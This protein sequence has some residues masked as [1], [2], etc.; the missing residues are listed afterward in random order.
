VVAAMRRK[1]HTPSSGGSD[2]HTTYRYSCATAWVGEGGGG[3]RMGGG[4]TAALVLTATLLLGMP[5]CHSGAL[6]TAHGPVGKPAGIPPL[7][8]LPHP[9]AFFR[10]RAAPLTYLFFSALDTLGNDVGAPGVAVGTSACVYGYTGTLRASS[11]NKRPGCQAREDD[12][13]SVYGYGTF[14]QTVG[15]SYHGTS[16]RPRRMRR[17][18]KRERG[19]FVLTPSPGSSFIAGFGA[20]EANDFAL[21][22]IPSVAISGVEAVFSLHGLNFVPGGMLR[23]RSPSP[24][25]FPPL[26][27]PTPHQPAR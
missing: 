27:P 19:G 26:P 9:N 13:T 2:G 3:G 21:S 15:L 8:A 20:T 22:A 14:E 1:R 16:A 12:A 6:N 10:C 24:Q 4:S 17:A 7:A 18:R 25:A 5:R 23:Q 11:W